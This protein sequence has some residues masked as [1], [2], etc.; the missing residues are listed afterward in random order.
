MRT[1]AILALSDA[2]CA[3]AKSTKRWIYLAT[4]K[5]ASS[6]A[7]VQ[8]AHTRELSHS[9]TLGW[10]S[11]QAR[12]FPFLHTRHRDDASRGAR[13]CTQYRLPSSP[14]DEHGCFTGP[15]SA[16]A[17][18]QYMHTLRMMSRGREQLAHVHGCASG[19]RHAQHL[20][21]WRSSRMSA[22]RCIAQI[23]WQLWFNQN[24]VSRAL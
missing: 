5:S 23:A 15:T 12:P 22:T 4:L 11:S 9:H 7:F 13:W 3:V 1:F 6:A 19:L 21:G 24:G 8:S 17:S 20:S 14:H 18:L 2:N 16:H 10:S